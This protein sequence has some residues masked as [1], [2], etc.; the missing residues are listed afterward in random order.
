[1]LLLGVDLQ[2]THMPASPLL[3]KAL[4]HNRGS[5]GAVRGVGQLPGSLLLGPRLSP[6]AA[7]HSAELL[8]GIVRTQPQYCQPH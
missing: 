3:G 2:D 1:M 6:R 8:W 4:L 5:L 7:L